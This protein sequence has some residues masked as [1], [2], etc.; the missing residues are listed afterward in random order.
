MRGFR[1]RTDEVLGL[2]KTT[3]GSCSRTGHGCCFFSSGRK[4]DRKDVK[5]MER[6]G[7]MA[8]EAEGNSSR[9]RKLGH[10]RRGM[11]LIGGLRGR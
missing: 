2:T 8:M 7:A 10:G 9:E 4:A 6:K 5:L 1:S 3:A 11:L